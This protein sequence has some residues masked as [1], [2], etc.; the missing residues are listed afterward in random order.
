MR[1]SRLIQSGL[2]DAATNMA[3]DEALFL[4]HKENITP[5]T[6]RLYGWK[7]YALS[8][9]ISQDPS[10]VL[11]LAACAEKN[12]RFVRRPTGGGVLYHGFELTYSL[13]LSQRDLGLSIRV[14]ESFEKITSFVIFALEK[15]GAQAAFA[16]NNF[17]QQPPHT[18]IADFCFSRKE[19]YDIVIDNKKI[20]G[21]AQKRKK[22]T[23]LQHGVL[24]FVFDKQ[25]ISCFLKDPNLIRSSD[26]TSI[27]DIAPKIDFEGL[28]H[29]LIEAFC[30]HF[31][32]TLENGT[33]TREEKQLARKLKKDQ[34]DNDE[35]NTKR[36]AL[37]KA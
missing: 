35:W 18:S 30:L 12:I 37:A 16:K 29:H 34:Y 7:P 20:G 22:N 15:L 3:I 9:G 33:L 8:I 27:N 21:N 11:N 24:P 4:A 31:Q 6:L 32:T 23:I 28:S 10:L 36:R 2:S 25:K 13:V 1:P 19:E 17:K 14:K 26:V 5:P